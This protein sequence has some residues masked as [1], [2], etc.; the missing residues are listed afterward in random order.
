MKEFTLAQISKKVSLIPLH[1]SEQVRY[2][3]KILNNCL[4]QDPWN[5][6]KAVH[7]MVLD[8]ICD[9]N[10]KRSFGS[11]EETFF[12]WLKIIKKISKHY[13]KGKTTFLEKIIENSFGLVEEV[14][15]KGSQFYEP[16]DLLVVV[17][18]SQKTVKKT[19]ILIDLS[20]LLFNSFKST[21]LL[22][23]SCLLLKTLFLK[24][25]QD[26]F[27]V[28]FRR[29]LPTFHTCLLKVSKESVNKK[30]IMSTLKM[31]EFF[32]L[33][34]FDEFL[35]FEGVLIFTLQE[36]LH[37]LNET[38]GS[39]SSLELTTLSSR[40]QDPEPDDFSIWKLLPSSENIRLS[41]EHLLSINFYSQ[42]NPEKLS[43]L[44]QESIIIDLIK[45]Y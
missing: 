37:E 5:T 8:V 34:S 10:F 9:R 17:V 33:I 20:D 29:I 4:N 39:V 22:P 6:S 23:T 7:G 14:L 27:Q 19:Q 35:S 28:L 11:C 24:L 1:H 16:L 38:L 40:F 36:R 25:E 2:L 21:E 41:I 32:K 30:E 13:Y 31:I 3:A 18:L 26:D 44:I 12:D 45:L 43:E 15:T 42:K